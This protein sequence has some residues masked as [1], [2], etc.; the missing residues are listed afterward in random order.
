[1][2]KKKRQLDCEVYRNVL[3]MNKLQEILLE[4]K[5]PL[6]KLRE[7]GGEKRLRKQER[8]LW[9]KSLSNMLEHNRWSRRSTSWLYKLR[10]SEMTSKEF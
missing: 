7:T 6:S 2:R 1:M 5:E 4:L 8:R 9:L 10:E 3:K